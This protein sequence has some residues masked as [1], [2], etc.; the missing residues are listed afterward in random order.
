ML[1][2]QPSVPLWCSPAASCIDVLTNSL[3]DAMGKIGDIVD[4]DVVPF[5][6]GSEKNGVI[7]CQHGAR[8][9]HANTLQGCAQSLYPTQSQWFAFIVCMEK[10]TDPLGA[11][12]RCAKAHG[13]S[14][15]KIE[16][17][18]KGDDGRKIL[19]ANARRTLDL[20]PPN[21]Y[22]PWITVNGQPYEDPENI[23]R[24]VCSQYTAADKLSYCN[25]R[26]MQRYDPNQRN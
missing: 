19:F 17:C 26:T 1:P 22:V 10:T 3:R 9:C 14:W 2:S 25:G 20:S 8:E 11:A 21:K 5:G 23:I 24:A 18:A 12:P 7:S 6:N 16:R 13:M 4:L 15:T